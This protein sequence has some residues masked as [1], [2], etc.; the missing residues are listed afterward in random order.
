MNQSIRI[1]DKEQTAKAIPFPELIESLKLAVAQYAAKEINCPERI[2]VPLYGDG[3]SLSMP[4]SAKDLSI[5]KL[6]NVQPAN[7]AAGMPTIQGIVTVC[8][9]MTGCPVML[10]DGPEV[11][12]R[13]TA[14]ISLLAIEKFHVGPARRVLLIGTGS[15]SSYH[16]QGMH[17]I[18]PDCEILIRGTNKASEELFSQQHKDIHSR[19]SPCPAQIPEDVDVVITLTTSKEVIYNEPPTLTRLVIGVGAF[20][21]VM[22]ELGSITL[23][24]S[25][26]YVDDLAGAKHE[27]GDLLRAKIDWSRVKSLS[28]SSDKTK[29]QNPIVVKSVGSAAWDLAAARVA[30]TK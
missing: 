18:Y 11:T 22:A 16:V 17:A 30:Y 5:H 10:L 29:L 14:G 23:H 19:I 8:D 7:K 24:G 4:A 13:R 9:A 27:A 15:Q 3:I 12:G 1:F 2:G 20:K 26:I 21:P 25:D 28:V 6:V